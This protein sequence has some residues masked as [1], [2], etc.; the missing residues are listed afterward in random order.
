MHFISEDLENYVLKPLFSFSGSGVEL[1]VN[2]KMISE[3][4]DPSQYILQKKI[5]Y[6][7]C[8]QT[9][10]VNAKVE[11]RLMYAWFEQDDQPM[12]VITLARLSKGSMVGVKYNQ[13]RTWVGSS[14]GLWDASILYNKSQEH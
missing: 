2:S 1:N 9:P 8:I 3:L 5:D 7:P 4:V 13:N 11:I 12:P 10:D 6:A 14:V